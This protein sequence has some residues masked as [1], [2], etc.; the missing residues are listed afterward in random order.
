MGQRFMDLQTLTAQDENDDPASAWMDVEELDESV[1]Y[2]E[3]TV[4]SGAAPTVQ[5]RLEGRRSASHNA[6]T[7]HQFDEQVASADLHQR[8]DLKGFAQVREVVPIGGTTVDAD[9]T[10]YLGQQR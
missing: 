8:V 9:I 2:H 1:Y 7:I 5:P 6:V 4:N 3:L 10:S